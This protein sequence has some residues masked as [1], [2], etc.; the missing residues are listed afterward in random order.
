MTS[1][2]RCRLGLCEFQPDRRRQIQRLPFLARLQLQAGFIMLH[3]FS[4]QLQEDL[5]GEFLLPRR[6]QGRQRAAQIGQLRIKFQK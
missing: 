4:Q 5:G 1:S 3:F 2:S 6:P